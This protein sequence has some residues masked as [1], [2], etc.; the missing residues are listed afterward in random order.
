M[1]SLKRDPLLRTL[2]I[3]LVAV[4]AFGLLYPLLFGSTGYMGYGSNMGMGQHYGMNGAAP[5]NSGLGLGFS[6]TGLLGLIIK[7]L[8]VLLIV[9]LVVGI[10]KAIKDEVSTEKSIGTAKGFVCAT[11]DQAKASEA[12]EIC[13]GCGKELQNDWKVCPYC[14]KEK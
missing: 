9:G 14:A 10:I 5:Y 11:P 13:A 1:E 4:L 12:K 7:V 3:I 6:L 2:F 8:F